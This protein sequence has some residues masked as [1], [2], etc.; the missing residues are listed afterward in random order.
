[1]YAGFGGI[2][3]EAAIPYDDAHILTLPAFHWIKVDSISAKNPRYGHSCN[4]VG[5]SQI[6]SIGGVDA[7]PTVAAPGPDNLTA[8]ESTLNTTTDPFTQG[9]AIF[10][11]TALKFGSGYEANASSYIQSDPVVQ[12]YAT[13]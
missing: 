9:L 10:N 2:L 1:M 7:N 8:Y 13:K 5:G 4:A 11:M 6:L 3:G 12:Y